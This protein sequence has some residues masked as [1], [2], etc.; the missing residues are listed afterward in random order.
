[1]KVKHELITYDTIEVPI[2]WIHHSANHST[3]SIVPHWHSSLELFY[4]RSGT[5]HEIKIEGMTYET[6]PG[7]VLVVNS[8]EVHS[9]VPKYDK[10]LDAMTFVISY[11]LLT[12]LIPNL[13]LQTFYHRTLSFI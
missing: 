1:M 3:R 8:A 11:E 10:E 6:Y 9:I 12:S 4:M 5:N 13:Y 7:M 2:K